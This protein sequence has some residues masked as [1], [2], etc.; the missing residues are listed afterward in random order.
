M[1]GIVPAVNVRGTVGAPMVA[2]MVVLMVV[3]TV[4]LAILMTAPV[5]VTAVQSPGLVMALLIVKIKHMVVT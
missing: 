2:P 4:M 3:A 1:A 5:M